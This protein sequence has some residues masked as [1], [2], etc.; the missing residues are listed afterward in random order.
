LPK[1]LQA[2]F[3][4][5]SVSLS[6]LFKPMPNINTREPVAKS[7][8]I[9]QKDQP[10]PF[11]K[12]E[13]EPSKEP[14]SAPLFANWNFKLQC[15]TLIFEG[16]SHPHTT[17]V[18]LMPKKGKSS[19]VGA[20]FAPT[21]Q[22]VYKIRSV[23]WDLVQGPASSASSSSAGPI[24]RQFAQDFHS[25]LRVSPRH[26]D[27]P[28]TFRPLQ[29]LHSIHFTPLN[30]THSTPP[31]SQDIVHP[32]PPPPNLIPPCPIPSHSTP[33]PH[34]STPHNSEHNHR[35]SRKNNRRRGKALPS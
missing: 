7:E 35:H 31:P 4:K 3:K 22:E 20:T 26:P 16:E 29:P 9:E 23:W 21:K 28:I 5:Q 27:S 18:Q 30:Y 11:V 12:Q 24:V 17:L 14:Q 25:S 32:T 15:A 8:P 6:S 2:Q 33:S 1:D 13:F 19:P 34:L 10:T